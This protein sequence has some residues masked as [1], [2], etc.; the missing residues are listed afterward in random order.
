MTTDFQAF[1]EP[2]RVFE[3]HLK[4]RFS[5]FDLLH[6][7]LRFQC[8]HNWISTRIHRWIDFYWWHWFPE[9]LAKLHFEAFESCQVL[10]QIKIKDL[11]DFNICISFQ[12]F[13]DDVGA[14]KG[15]NVAFCRSY[16]DFL[17]FCENNSQIISKF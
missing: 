13:F 2:V 3:N 7:Q 12:C 4:K 5:C 1:G 16:D 6:L 15:K 11:Q 14:V 8:L 9:C 10:K 17:R